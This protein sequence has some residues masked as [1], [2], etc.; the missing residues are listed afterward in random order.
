VGRRASRH[1]P[2]AGRPI[3][4]GDNP[5]DK[6][7]LNEALFSK[8]EPLPFGQTRNL[9][10][11]KIMSKIQ[12]GFKRLHL[13]F[14]FG[15]LALALVIPPSASSDETNVAAKK[16]ENENE[17]TAILSTV[18]VT[19]ERFPVSEKEAPR[20]VTVVSSDQLKET[21][22]NNL[23]DALRRV[24]GL[25][26]KSF[27]PLGVSQGGMNSTLSIRGI[28]DGELVLMNGAPIQGVAG[29]A[30]DLNTIPIDQIERIEILKGAA[31]TLYGADAMSGVINIIT[32]KPRQETAFK[33]S[34][35]FGNK[36]YNDHSVSAFLP[37]LNI[38]LDYQHLGAQ[39]DISRNFS[40]KYNYDQNKTDK[41]AWN[42]NAKLMNNLYLDYLGSYLDAGYKKHYDGNVKP[43]EGTD[44]QMQKNFVNL[45]YETTNLSARAFGSYDVMILG[46]YPVSTGADDKNKNY[47]AGLSGDYRFDLSGW[48]FNAGA[49]WVYRGADYNNQ[50]GEHHRN[51]FAPF[52]QVKKTL[53]ERLI[54]TM[55]AREQFVIGE[56]GTDDYQRFLPSLGLTYKVTEK[57]NLFANA[58]KAFRAPTFN[59]LYY[60]ST[61]LVGNPNLKPEEG[62]TYETGTKYENDTFT[63]RLSGF[64]MTYTD[65]IE[66]DS[67]KAPQSYRN[68]TSYESRGLEWKLELYPFIHQTARKTMQGIS[69]YTAG[70]WADP[71]GEDI[72]GNEYQTGPKLQT[73]LGI[74]CLSGP[75]VLDLNSEIVAAR[76]KNLDSY[77]VLNFY[78]KHKLWKGFL[79]FGVDNIF[80]KQ[81]ET[82]G[83]LTEGGTN[84][85]AYYDIG[86]LF[87][88]GYEITF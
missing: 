21:G 22:A 63:L 56:S 43:Y 87:K 30:Y 7:P 16:A 82:T 69:L 52:V 64:Y 9:E 39:T 70:Y 37:N 3:H 76:E 11:E 40:G 29:H 74:N 12:K 38:G 42:I 26:Y 75:L 50:Y 24:G 85:Y 23:A 27:L 32:K 51:D 73:S 10:G 83:D 25:A 1:Q 45:R 17:H 61:F 5:R 55:G 78:G 72:K 79:T 20:V 48:E 59:N 88:I 19:A 31:S 57:L 49:D 81:V 62:W 6:V 18:T 15:L 44:E 41:Y 67:S 60:K 66:L 14:A 68:A 4:D 28:K 80:D 13:W 46:K 53:W 65:K 71:K 77:A 35:E 2:E 58:G 33:A 54:A 84:R 86:R 8:K 36:S 34:A 47:N